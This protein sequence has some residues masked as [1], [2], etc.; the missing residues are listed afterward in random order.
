MHSIRTR[1]TLMTVSA[2]VITM[3]V[4]TVFGVI[5][6]N[7]I[8]S[9]SANRML[10]LLCE[11]GEKN[12]DHYFESVEQSVEMVSAYV[13]SDLDGLDAARLQAHLD[14]VSEI[15]EKLTYKT[16][17][18]LT[19][20]YRIDPAV[21]A[22]AKGFW[23]VNL[24]GNGFVEHEVT[25]ITLYDTE[26]TS[27]L[28]WFT[29]PKATGQSV[30]LPPYITDNLDVRVLSYN[31]PVY[32]HGRFVGVIG[33]EIDYSTMAD[34]VNHITL[35]DNG[36]AFINDAE[37]SLIYHPHIDVTTME[38]A[39]KAPAELLAANTGVRYRYDGVEKQA[40]WLPLSNGMHLNVSVPV[41]EINEDWQAWTMEIVGTFAV[42]LL[43]FVALILT[44][45]ARITKPLRELTAL[46][47]QVEAGNFDCALDY[48]GQDEVGI[49][50]RTFNQLTAHLKTTISDLSDLA[51]ADALTSLHNKGA[52][53]ICVRNMQASMEESNEKQEFAVCIFDCNDLK[54]I[55]DRYGHDKGDVYLK[56]T[57]SIICQV[58][59]HS[60]VFR[61]GG[62]EFAALLTGSDYQ[63]RD[64][65]L[66]LFD[67]RCAETGGAENAW[68]RANVAR[69]MAVFDAAEDETVSDVARRAD[70][71]MYE[72]KWQSKQSRRAR[73]NA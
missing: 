63:D 72:N 39:P 71:L 5:A 44:F 33:I 8:G 19:Y 17:G 27:K 26:D 47:E 67:E 65:L 10:Y 12:L 54:K 73:E 48:S 30:W 31:V 2:I 68:E 52:F 9:R 25:D 22:G 46:A 56:L 57:A 36:Y 49:L 18:V 43:V 14:R 24:D 21:S 62:D 28:V 38:T 61:I 51:Y 60:P 11:T 55:N 4:A 58:F 7:N 40:V 69:G 66:R 16:N 35:Y 53:D 41:R 34:E 29:V 6:I 1:I 70:K 3:A 59:D 64:A 50:T 42:L 37:G 15:F 20:Y 23:Y 45:T 32:Y 13:E